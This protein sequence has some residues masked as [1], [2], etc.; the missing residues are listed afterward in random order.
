MAKITKI[1]VGI[2]EVKEKEFLNLL[3]K[4]QWPQVCSSQVGVSIKQ[5]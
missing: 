3:R 4:S 5:L 2:C 1:L